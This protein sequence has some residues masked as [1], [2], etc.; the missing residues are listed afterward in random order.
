[1]AILYLLVYLHVFQHACKDLEKYVPLP[2]FKKSSYSAIENLIFA[3]DRDVL[4][5]VWNVVLLDF[6]LSGYAGFLT[7]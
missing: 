1:M 7:I 5:P 4:I 3:V 2:S 6:A